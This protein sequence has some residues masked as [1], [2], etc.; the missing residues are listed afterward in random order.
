MH[1]L[2]TGANGFIGRALTAA[3]RARGHSVCAGVRR[4]PRSLDARGGLRYVPVDFLTDVESADWLPRLHG[5]DA[6]VN[7]VGILRERGR[8]T[9]AR[10]HVEAPVA[11]FTACAQAGIARVLQLSALGADAHAASDYHRS[12]RAADDALLARIPGAVCAQP[13]LVYGEGGASARLFTRLA[14]LPLVP[15]PGAGTQQVQPIHLDDLVAVLC[16]LVERPLGPG[17]KIALVGPTPLTLRELL[18]ELRGGLAL[19]PA[20][21]VPIPRPLIALAARAGDV[22]P[23]LLLDR[24]TLGM[25]ERGNTAD[26]GDTR[27]LLGHPPR[28]VFEFIAPDNAAQVRLR[29]R[30]GWLL[31][32]LRASVALVWI[33]TG[34]VSL[35][36]YPV[37]QS[38]ALLAR[39]GA[40]GVIAT[41]LLYAAGVLDLLLGVLVFM[42]HGAA[43]RWL[44]RAQA[45]LIIGYSVIIALRLPEFWLHP[46]GPMLKNVPLVAV[47]V[48]L[49]IL[50]DEA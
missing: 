9:F 27:R 11:L 40:T 1:I 12:K 19:P 50:E 43:R 4:A 14:S 21:F 49:D 22:M 41:V 33:V 26:P 30:L 29:A 7:T 13:S 17:G 45:L 20:R 46:Y 6:V 35:G 5:I 34:I 3:L 48:A 16:A 42:L 10:L 28:P 32:L 36:L 8:A 2:V 39:T 31:P 37:E 38:Y 24:A 47:L 15:L 25:L 23:G 44:W 18:A